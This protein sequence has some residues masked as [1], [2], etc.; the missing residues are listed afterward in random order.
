MVR[1]A[2]DS[3]RLLRGLH[4]LHIFK[5]S[6]APFCGGKIHIQRKPA[7]SVSEEH[8]FIRPKVYKTLAVLLHPVVGNS[9]A[10]S[11][12]AEPL[13]VLVVLGSLV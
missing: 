3:K 12:K 6:V 8:L 10:D 5:P 7:L 9:R 2:A 4:S 1:T 11:V 13:Q